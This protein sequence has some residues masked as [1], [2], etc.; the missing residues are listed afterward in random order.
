M[1][2][3]LEIVKN[4]FTSD[5]LEQHIFENQG[6]SSKDFLEYIL[7]PGSIITS[8]TIGQNGNIEQLFNLYGVGLVAGFKVYSDFSDDNVHHYGSSHG[9]FKGHHAMVIVGH[10]KDAGNHF[11]LLQNWWKKKQ[12]IEVD[13]QYLEQSGATIYFVKTQQTK[14]LDKFSKHFGKVFELELVDKPEGFTK[15]MKKVM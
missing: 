13:S 14:I 9:I 3:L 2:D 15:E 12:F 11:Y 1:I 5:Q 10:R 7:E 8:G 6:G 4:N